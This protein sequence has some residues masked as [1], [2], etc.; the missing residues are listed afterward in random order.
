[1]DTGSIVL[2]IL[3]GLAIITGMAGL[4]LPVLPGPLLLFIGLVLAAW[5]E[6]FSHVG[7]MT[8]TVL[9]LI[10]LLAH[11]IDFIAGV[12]GA[13]KFGAHRRA[14]IGGAIGAVLG[15]FFGF[16]GI[17]LGPFI[18]AVLGQLSAS[19]DLKT[20]GRAGLGTWIGLILG[21]AVKIALGFTMIGV[22]V[23]VRFL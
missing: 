20:A 4:I 14:L 21:T 1:M 18:G 9:A 2:L 13:R 15:I 22:F 5:A 8:I 11:V 6:D 3:A 10:A 17:I 7:G 19:S 23:M 16:I 12:L